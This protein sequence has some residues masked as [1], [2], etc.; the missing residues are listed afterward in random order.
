M[1]IP[2]KARKDAGFQTGDVVSVQ[3]DGDGR[4][5]L[6][7]LET[8]KAGKPVKAKI[9]KRRGKHPVGDIGRQITREEIKNALDE[10]P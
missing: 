5:V 3:P 2:A 7:R 4:I 1:V 8:P 6:I 10:F 9:I